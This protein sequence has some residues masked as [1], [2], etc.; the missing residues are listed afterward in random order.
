MVPLG[1]RSGYF[2]GLDLGGTNIKG[3]VVDESGCPWRRPAPT[4]SELGPVV[5]LGALEDVAHRAVKAS[6]RDWSEIVAV[7]LGS[8][9]T[10]DTSE[11]RIVDAS[12]LP[13]G[14]ASRSARG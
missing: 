10:L 12:N 14:T 8:A 3:G 6:G 9:G 7:G 1:R 4:R 13:A 2:L 5:G 11:G